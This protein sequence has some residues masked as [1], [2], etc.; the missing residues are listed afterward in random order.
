VAAALDEGLAC[1]PI[2][3]AV[4]RYE[5]RSLRPLLVS[6]EVGA[7]FNGPVGLPELL[8]PGRQRTHRL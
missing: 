5:G 7:V 2:P 1:G 6:S 8:N 4:F 3:L